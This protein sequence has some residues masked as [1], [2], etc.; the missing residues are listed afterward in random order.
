M[1]T[2]TTARTTVR[3]TVSH[4]SNPI[5]EFLKFQLEN[6]H[7]SFSKTFNY[8]GTHPTRQKIYEMNEYGT[9]PYLIIARYVYL[10]YY[11]R[12]IRKPFILF[13]YMNDSFHESLQY[14]DIK[15][16]MKLSI[17]NNNIPILISVL[18][19]DGDIII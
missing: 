2:P 11:F 19:Y 13:F 7:P 6:I 14:L 3:P 16:A 9:S 8:F 5:D 1:T 12:R 4:S 18:S 10:Y 17:E 15:H